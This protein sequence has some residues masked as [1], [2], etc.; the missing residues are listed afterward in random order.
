MEAMKEKYPFDPIT[1]LYEKMSA[2]KI[3]KKLKNQKIPVGT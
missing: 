3:K 1:K 2:R